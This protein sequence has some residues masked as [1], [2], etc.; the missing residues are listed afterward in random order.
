MKN[1][2][3]LSILLFL[4]LLLCAGVAGALANEIWIIP[5]NKDTNKVVG[6]WTVTNNGQAY[7]SFAVPD[8][9]TLFKAARVVL[10][11]KADTSISYDLNISIAQN[12]MRHDAY[13][14]A[15]FNFPAIVYKEKLLEIDVSS[16]FPQLLY[17]GNDY[18]SLR[19]N[20]IKQGEVYLLGLRFQYEGPAGP[21]G[22]QGPEGPIGPQG[23]QGAQ[24]PAGPEGLQGPKGDIG[25]QGPKGDTG[26][27]GP[28]GPQGPQGEIGP[29]GLKGDTGAQGPAGPTGATGPAGPIGSTGPQGPQGEQGPIGLTGAQGAQG[30]KGDIG[31]A[32]PQGPKGDAG[33]QGPK[34]DTGGV[35]P[36]GP[37][38]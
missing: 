18:V 33:P 26:A 22:P 6:N 37:Q 38:V 17:A 34:G 36:A 28:A 13:I 4:L 21:T 14:D 7:F 3:T 35:G 25:P 31:P 9:M 10:I 23:L 24:G 1:K 15:R 2:T 32:G 5:D 8:N 12:L 20:S 11:G 30:P 29:Q 16:I 19:F 27:V